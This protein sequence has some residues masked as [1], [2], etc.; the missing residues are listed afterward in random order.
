M[1]HFFF[2][3]IKFLLPLTII[4]TFAQMVWSLLQLYLQQNRLS[5]QGSRNC[6]GLTTYNVRVPQKHEA[7]IA[8]AFSIT[9]LKH[10]IVHAKTASLHMNYV[11]LEKMFSFLSHSYS[12]FHLPINSHES[13]S[14][15]S[16][17]KKPHE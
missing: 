4:Q 5:G 1:L 13:L 8:L 2:F 17:Q 9:L 7:A 3:L 16:H 15:F 14:L 11:A 6:A 12:L 10:H